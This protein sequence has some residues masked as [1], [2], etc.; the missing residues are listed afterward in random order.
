MDGNINNIEEEKKRRL[1]K[2]RNFR[3]LARKKKKN[4]VPKTENLLV[5][6]EK[7]AKHWYILV[8]AGIF[9]LLGLVL[10][11]SVLSNFAFGLLL[12]LYFGPKRKHSSSELKGIVLP[13]FIGSIFDLFF[14]VLPVNIAAALIRIALDE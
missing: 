3:K 7:I 4:L 2:I 14:S 13:I 8:V 1:Q 11:I 12:F 6:R 10:I 5:F 9:D